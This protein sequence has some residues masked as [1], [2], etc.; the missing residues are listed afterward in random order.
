MNTKHYLVISGIIGGVIGSLLTALLVS[1]VTAQRDKFGHIECT[2]L[3]VVDG[4]QVKVYDKDGIGKVRLGIVGDGGAVS[5]LGTD[6]KPKVGLYVNEHG[7]LIGILSKDGKPKVDLGVNEHGGQVL[8]SDKDRQGG[9]RVVTDELGGRVDVFGGEEGKIQ[10]A[11]SINEHGGQVIVK[12]KGG[13]VDLGVLEI[14]GMVR[15][16]DVYDKVTQVRVSL[17]SNGDFASVNLYPGISTFPNV[18]L[19]SGREYTPSVGVLSNAGSASLLI[20]EHGG[21]VL[22]TR[23]RGEDREVIRMPE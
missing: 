13:Q 2:G 23:G 22:I 15:V 4:G 5:V 18:L 16:Y 10:A 1:P 14:G 6:G 3:T 17:D 7:G 12:G 8:V 9:V 11:L 19:M 20:G 21:E